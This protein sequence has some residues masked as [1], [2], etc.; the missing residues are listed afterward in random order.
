MKKFLFS[1]ICLLVFGS[2]LFGWDVY[3]GA[4]DATKAVLAK[5]D[6]LIEQEQYQS[7]FGATNGE[8]CQE[9]YLLAKRI[10]IATNYFAQSIMH[11]MF[12]FK[13]LEEG[14]TLYDV[15]TGTGD[16]S[17]MMFDPVAAVESFM[18]QNGE[19]PVLYYALGAYY[20]D[21]RSR[22][23]DQW[24]IT[25]DEL[26]EKTAE[27]FRKAYDAGVYDAFSLSELGMSYAYLGDND[28]AISI[29]EAK[30][31]QYELTGDDDYNYGFC[32]LR[33]GQTEKGA[34]Y[35][36]NSID[37]Y[38]DNPQYQYDSYSLVVQ[39]Y[40][41][42]LKDFE[43]AGKILL[44]FK[45]DFPT[46]Y[47]VTLFTILF[48]AAQNLNDQA[49]ES[50]L[51]LFAIAP[52]NPSACQLIMQQGQSAGNMEFLPGFFDQALVL[53][54]ENSGAVAN[55]Y[56]HYAYTLCLMQRN[57]E[58]WNMVLKAREAFTQN[59]TLTS[60]IEQSLD[61]IQNQI[62]LNMGISP[63]AIKNMM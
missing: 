34:Y 48:Y 63:D 11:Q 62:M 58:A 26:Y 39:V 55:L 36:E 1:L 52:T 27:N 3:S 42:T 37:K 19:K 4:N 53:Y 43:S 56:F 60:D 12:A 45:R 51:E 15:R 61:Q 32:F 59:G 5:V 25:V 13:N 17:L 28:S 50:S 7:A 10:E 2:S 22:Y 20:T 40:I 24:L 21:V 16:Y 9:E 49:I 54:A 30:E 46:D 33:K 6:A 23:G 18:E 57:E 14:Q 47:R 41:M 29:Y 8:D 44:N 31:K 35:L 38:A